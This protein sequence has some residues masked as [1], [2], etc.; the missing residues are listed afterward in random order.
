MPLVD[1]LGF[2]T[3]TMSTLIARGSSA[4]GTDDDV[5]STS[6]ALPLTTA[7]PFLF[8]VVSG[9]MLDARRFSGDDER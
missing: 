5:I 9:S 7:S 3:S 6:S 1:D 8:V 2:E 4:E